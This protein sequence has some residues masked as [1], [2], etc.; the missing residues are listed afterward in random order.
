M[1]FSV[2]LPCTKGRKLL[3]IRIY[4]H[5]KHSKMVDCDAQRVTF[6]GAF[7]K[8]ESGIDS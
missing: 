4:K 7:S 1:A 5:Y 8:M 3:A 2:V 6:S